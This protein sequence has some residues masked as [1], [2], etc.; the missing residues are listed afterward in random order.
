LHTICADVFGVESFVDDVIRSQKI[1]DRRKA[2]RSILPRY[3]D[4]T[5]EAATTAFAPIYIRTL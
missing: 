5:L 2:R 3:Y 4:M 1:V